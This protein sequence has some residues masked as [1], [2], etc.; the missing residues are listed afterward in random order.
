MI[1][2][3]ILIFIFEISIDGYFLQAKLKNL[4]AS[5]EKL[6]EWSVHGCG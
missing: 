5:L 2:G 3:E 1:S 4:I 6:F